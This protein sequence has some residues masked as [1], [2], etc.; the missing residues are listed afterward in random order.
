MTA[1]G[2]K[3]DRFNQMKNTLLLGFMWDGLRT[4]LIT[5]LVDRICSES[6]VYGD[7]GR[8][9]LSAV[10]IVRCV[11]ETTGKFVMPNYFLCALKLI[12]IIIKN[13]SNLYEVNYNGY[14]LI[15][16]FQ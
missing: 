5:L 12:F 8:V 9:K 14:L 3:K 11:L 16:Q 1:S 15:F 7:L 13:L 2:G 4:E 10:V 6:Q